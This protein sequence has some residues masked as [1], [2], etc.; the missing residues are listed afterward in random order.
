MNLNN[1]CI[2]EPARPS[3]AA[4]AARDCGGVMLRFL[5]AAL[6]AGALAG[7]ASFAPLPFNSATAQNVEP[8]SG[9]SIVARITFA[10]NSVPSSAPFLFKAP[11]PAALR[12][13]VARFQAAASNIAIRDALSASDRMV[14]MLGMMIGPQGNGSKGLHDLMAAA[15]TWQHVSSNSWPATQPRLALERA[16]YIRYSMSRAMGRAEYSHGEMRVY[17][18]TGE[19]IGDA[20]YES[21]R[22]T[23]S[24]MY[25]LNGS[26]YV[27][28]E[29][30][31]WVQ[32]VHDKGKE[33]EISPTNTIPW[34]DFLDVLSMKMRNGN[35][36]TASIRS[37]PKDVELLTIVDGYT[38]PVQKFDVLDLTVTPQAIVCGVRIGKRNMT[39]IGYSALDILANLC[40]MNRIG[41]SRDLSGEKAFEDFEHDVSTVRDRLFFVPEVVFMPQ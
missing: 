13:D 27:F 35:L 7:C 10:S 16:A 1:N 40:L 11:N 8:A 14:S 3:P 19:V 2:C 29:A 18:P 4:P 24:L 28:R 36:Q 22:G 31:T 38:L 23:V 30:K 39:I 15:A 21:K 26:E 6:A 5:F 25:R 32:T 34:A 33:L 20:G 37:Q 17:G 9:T 41:A 12:A